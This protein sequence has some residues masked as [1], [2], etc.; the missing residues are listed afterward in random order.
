MAAL[1]GEGYIYSKSDIAGIAE[2]RQRNIWLGTDN[3]IIRLQQA[4]KLLMK[5][6]LNVSEV[7]Y[8]VGFNDPNYF[9]RCYLREF[10]E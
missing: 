1:K 4:R 10:G 6:D 5:T 2:D 7:A 9:S 8:A 3:A